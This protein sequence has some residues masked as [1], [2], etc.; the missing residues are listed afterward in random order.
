MRNV[1]GS[2]LALTLSAVPVVAAPAP[3]AK[4]SPKPDPAVVVEQ[5]KQ[6]MLREHNTYAD[7]VVA[8]SQ[9]NEWI[10][11]GN[12]PMA[13]GGQLEYA[14]QRYRVTASAP[15]RQ[16]GVRFTVTVISHY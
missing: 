7:N 2:L 13:P 8:G 9:P 14:Q 5:L 12:V 6:F 11:T 1:I 3:F 16:G 10:I 15:D 4:P